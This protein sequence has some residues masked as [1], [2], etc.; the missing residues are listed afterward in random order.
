MCC[1]S[2]FD[3]TPAVVAHMANAYIAFFMLRYFRKSPPKF[4]VLPEKRNLGALTFFQWS[5]CRVVMLDSKLRWKNR[6]FVVWLDVLGREFQLKTQYKQ[7]PSWPGPTVTSVY[8]FVILIF[9]VFNQISFHSK[10]LFSLARWVEQGN[11]NRHA[12]GNFFFIHLLDKQI[13]SIQI[14]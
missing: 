12:S 9:F 4:F 13:E 10:I 14:S 1:R 6:K 7:S 2:S 11:N 5:T 8:R 3:I